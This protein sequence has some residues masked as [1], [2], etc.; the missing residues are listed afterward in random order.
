MARMQPLKV[1]VRPLRRGWQVTSSGDLRERFDC[2]R[3]ANDF[4][5]RFASALMRTGVAVELHP[6]GLDADCSV[7]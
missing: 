3:V 5:Q 7:A 4:A 6:L 2:P 1:H